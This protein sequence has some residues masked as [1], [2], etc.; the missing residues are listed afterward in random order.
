MD[1]QDHAR[2]IVRDYY[3]DRTSGAERITIDDV[4]LVWYCKT[5]QNWK[6]LVITTARDAMIYEVSYDG[7][8][9]R[10]Y[11]DTYRKIDNVVVEDGPVVV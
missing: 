2:R 3:N 9:E 6:A 5:L 4:L 1:G 8:Q 10:A 11:L 7:D